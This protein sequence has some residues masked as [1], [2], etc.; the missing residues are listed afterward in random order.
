MKSFGFTKN[1]SMHIKYT[2]AACSLAK[3]ALL[4]FKS[5]KFIFC[6]NRYWKR[7]HTE[8]VHETLHYKHMFNLW[9]SS[10]H[11]SPPS[12]NNEQMGQIKRLSC[13][14]RNNSKFGSV[15]LPNPIYANGQVTLTSDNKLKELWRT[16]ATWTW[17]QICLPC[18]WITD[19]FWHFICF[20]FV[21]AKRCPTA[22]GNLLGNIQACKYGPKFLQLSKKL[23]DTQQHKVRN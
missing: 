14:K 20:C 7:T 6:H 23:R 16:A 17:S 12:V 2:L 10:W 4:I 15:Y 22:P 13:R 19:I 3:Q 9:F 21:T 8:K 18:V 11:K 5:R 1:L